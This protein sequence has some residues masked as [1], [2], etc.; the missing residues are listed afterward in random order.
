MQGKKTKATITMACS[1]FRIIF[2]RH[3]QHQSKKTFVIR[4]GDQLLTKHLVSRI[5]VGQNVQKVL[6]SP[7]NFEL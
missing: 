2:S 1:L 7:W 5:D 3:K 4:G 6:H